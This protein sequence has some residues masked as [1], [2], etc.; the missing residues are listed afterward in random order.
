MEFHLAMVY[1][2]GRIEGLGF[3]ASQHLDRC[4]LVWHGCHDQARTGGSSEAHRLTEKP[5]RG[6]E[7]RASSFG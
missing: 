1:D 5:H 6:L 4:C 2:F 3:R 7:L